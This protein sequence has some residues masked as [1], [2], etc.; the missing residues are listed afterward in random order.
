MNCNFFI[1]IE[2]ILK[3]DILI[4]WVLL[5][6]KEILTYIANLQSIVIHFI[7]CY[8]GKVILN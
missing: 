4:R 5:E 2:I 8:K 7:A 6:F 1:H 3:T